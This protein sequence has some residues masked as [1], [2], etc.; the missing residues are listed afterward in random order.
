MKVLMA[1]DGS[2]DAGTALRT[3][4]RLLKGD[5]NACRVLCVFP[6]LQVGARKTKSSKSG[7]DAARSKYRDRI[8]AEARRILDQAVVSLRGE[9]VEAESIIEQGSPADIIVRYSAD[10]DVTVIGAHGQYERTQPGFGPTA[11]RV[12]EHAQ[13]TVLVGRGLVAE[14]SFRVLAAVDGSL[15]STH[16]LRALAAHFNVLGAEITLLHVVEK[17]WI[18]LGLEDELF[19]SVSSGDPSDPAIQFQREFQ[20]EAEQVIEEARA[21]LEEWGLSATPMITEGDPGL[22]LL[23]EAETGEYDLVI[24]GATGLSDLKHTLLGSVSTRV[25][26]DAPCSVAVVKYHA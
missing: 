23:S 10:Y 26:R 24:I 15:A 11:A 13:N 2:A 14:K 3:A 16:A 1:T 7:T 25:A 20:I 12:V 8:A 19:D 6:E 18:R 4:S 22:E 21:S 5:R 17:P 9:G